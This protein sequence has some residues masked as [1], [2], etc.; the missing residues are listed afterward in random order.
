MDYIVTKET[1]IGDI[2]D[3]DRTTAEFFLEMG[4]HW[5]WLPCIPR[6]KPGRGLAQYT[7]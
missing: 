5:P 7:V 4:M 6:R 3:H 1:L 2:L